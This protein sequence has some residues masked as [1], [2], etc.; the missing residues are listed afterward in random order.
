MVVA[1]AENDV[2]GRGGTLPWHLPEDLTRFRTL[3]MGHA[4]VAGRNTHDS[5]VERLGHP[6]PGRFT[7]VVSRSITGTRDGAIYLPTVEDAMA[8]ARAIESFSGGDEIF[9]IGGAEVYRAT[10]DQVERIYLTRVHGQPEGDTT[11]P[12]GW[13]DGFVVVEDDERDGFTFSMWERA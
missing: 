4:V 8:A 9:V 7:L 6:L 2:I 5:I 11:M 10:L 12:G 1:A 3:T 13:L